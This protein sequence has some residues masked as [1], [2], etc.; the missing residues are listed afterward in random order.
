[1]FGDRGATPTDTQLDAILRG[2]ADLEA[3]CAV[4]DAGAAYA[5]AADTHHAEFKRTA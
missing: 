4:A 1:M 5:S 2:N 3:A